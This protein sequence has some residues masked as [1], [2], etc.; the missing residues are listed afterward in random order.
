MS[1][2]AAD[3][4]AAKSA[5]VWVLLTRHTTKAGA[6]TGGQQGAAA[7]AAREQG[8]DDYLTVHVFKERGGYRVYYLEQCWRQ[9]IYSNRPH[10]L[11][12]ACN[13]HHLYPP[14]VIVTACNHHL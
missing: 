8:T 5:S 6:H 4:G 9:G 1:V 11:V 12:Q 10:F 14:R 3:L 2:R 13:H 7:A